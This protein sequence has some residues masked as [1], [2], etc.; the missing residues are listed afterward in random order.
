VVQQPANMRDTMMMSLLGKY[1]SASQA[2]KE[3]IK[4]EA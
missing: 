2:A 3:Q 4:L 1:T